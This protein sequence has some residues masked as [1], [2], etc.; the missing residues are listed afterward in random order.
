MD[1]R[2]RHRGRR[3]RP[4]RTCLLTPSDT[5]SRPNVSTPRTRRINLP[6]SALS[7]LAARSTMC[8]DRPSLLRSDRRG[9]SSSTPTAPHASIGMRRLGSCGGWRN[10]PGSTNGSRRTRYGTHSSP[11]V[12]RTPRRRHNGQCGVQSSRATS[13]G[14]GDLASIEHLFGVGGGT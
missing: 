12:G 2:H 3:R 14:S 4:Y 11:R 8:A 5:G 1:H 13:S 7:G 9:R 6:R 10:G